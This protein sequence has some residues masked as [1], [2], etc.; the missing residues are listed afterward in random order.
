ML[1]VTEIFRKKIDSSI[2]LRHRIFC[3]VLD[4]IICIVKRVNVPCLR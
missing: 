2:D 1:S 4:G 3:V